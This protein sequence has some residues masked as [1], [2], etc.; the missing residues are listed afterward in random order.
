MQERQN[1]R[2]QQQRVPESM[3]AESFSQSAR[4]EEVPAEM[5]IYRLTQQVPVMNTPEK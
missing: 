5:P 1:A 2:Q 4:E 3:I